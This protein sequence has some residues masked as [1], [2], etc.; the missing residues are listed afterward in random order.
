[1]P[2][3]FNFDLTGVSRRFFTEIARIANESKLHRRLGG[4]FRSLVKR[5]RLDEATGLNISDAVALVE[6]FVDIQVRNMVNR[7][8]FLKAK[9]RALL[10]PHCSRKYMDSRCKAVFDPRVPAY[11]CQHC[12]EDCLINQATLLGER[13]GYDVYVLPG[14]SCV[15]K[16][17]EN[18]GYEAVVGVAC[19]EEIK[20]ASQILDKLKLPGQAVPL[21]KN[22]CAYTKFDISTLESIL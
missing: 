8:R 12:S 13:R 19:G 22:G 21:L 15:T 7:G 9:R 11:F 16:I 3:R 1:M 4:T 10:L 14:G 6:D 2:Y 5:F 17:L 18:G 20:L